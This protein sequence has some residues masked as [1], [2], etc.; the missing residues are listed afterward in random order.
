MF[1]LVRLN[2]EGK[3]LVL[4]TRPDGLV[5]PKRPC[6]YKAGDDEVKFYWYTDGEI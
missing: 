1:I 5:P 4:S 2:T 6:G 3:I